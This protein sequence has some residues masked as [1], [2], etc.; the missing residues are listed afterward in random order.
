MEI[1][2]WEYVIIL[3]TKALRKEVRIKY[4]ENYRIVKK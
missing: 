1:K 2:V 4:Y 3:C